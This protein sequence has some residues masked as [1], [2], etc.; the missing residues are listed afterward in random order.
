MCYQILKNQLKI[1]LNKMIVKL[2]LKKTVNIL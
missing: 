1:V 2:N